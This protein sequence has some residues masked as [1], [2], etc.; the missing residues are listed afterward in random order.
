MAEQPH[1][2]SDALGASE[3][4]AKALSSSGYKADFSLESLHEIDRFFDEQAPA[5]KARPRGLLS[6]QLGQRI[7]GLALTS[8]R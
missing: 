7:F 6:E 5:G 3:W 1:I 4:M 8:A 2:V